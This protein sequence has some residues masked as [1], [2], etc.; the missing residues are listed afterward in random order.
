MCCCRERCGFIKSFA[1]PAYI[2]GFLRSV[3]STI[4]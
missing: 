2:K 1:R 3:L 4:F